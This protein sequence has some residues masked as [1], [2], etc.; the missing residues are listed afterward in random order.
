MKVRCRLI[1][2]RTG[3][4][5]PGIVVS[6]S[7]SVDGATRAIPIS[8]LSSDATGY[9][10]FDLKPLVDLGI[11][12]VPGVYISAPQV[13][14]DQFD[15][16]GERTESAAATT[17]TPRSY[18]AGS[19]SA[20]QEDKHLCI[21][22]PIVVDR[23]EPALQETHALRVRFPERELVDFVTEQDPSRELIQAVIV[24]RVHLREYV[25]RRHA[26]PSDFG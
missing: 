20:N 7:V 12:D 18:V 21:E 24:G 1:D 11:D 23:P 4:P 13:A 15:L 10:S 16:M 6:L 25:G 5:V 8:T 19:G 2:R 26:G 3:Q 22:F 14:L 9:L 17:T